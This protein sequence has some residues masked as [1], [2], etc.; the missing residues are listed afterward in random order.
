M[1]LDVVWRCVALTVRMIE[2]R[3]ASHRHQLPPAD[4]AELTAN[5]GVRGG[6]P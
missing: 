3:D 5:L 6:V 1:Q 4:A 2:E